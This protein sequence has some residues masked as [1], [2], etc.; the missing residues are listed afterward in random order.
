MSFF[1]TNIF[2]SCVCRMFPLP[3][4]VHRALSFLTTSPPPRVPLSRSFQPVFCCF[5]H[6]GTPFFPFW[7]REGAKTEKSTWTWIEYS[8]H[9][10]I[11]STLTRWTHSMR[12]TSEKDMKNSKQFLFFLF[13]VFFFLGE[14]Q[15]FLFVC[16]FVLVFV[17]DVT[18]VKQDGSCSI[19]QNEQYQFSGQINDVFGLLR[20]RSHT[21]TLRWFFCEGSQTFHL[22]F[23]ERRSF[24]FQ[25]VVLR[26]QSTFSLCIK[27]YLTAQC[28]P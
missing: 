27:P 8:N 22:R 12:E 16:V 6:K 20:P 18:C 26:W 24:R 5:F 15:T 17:E 3:P 11:H 9:T 19:A 2:A 14:R 13:L 7:K 4:N 1:E 23:I 25:S 10:L 21:L 28:S